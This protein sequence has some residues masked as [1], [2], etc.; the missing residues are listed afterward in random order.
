MPD[1]T[2]VLD[3][4]DMR[5]T[6]VRI[7]HEIVEKNP[8]DHAGQRR[9]GAGPG[10]SGFALVGVHRRGAVLAERLHSLISE[11]GATD[12]RKRRSRSGPSTSAFYRDDLGIR[13]P[14]RARS[15]T[16]RSSTSRSTTARS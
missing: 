10:E 12:R 4:D 14:E 16:P 2:V 7:A 5:R 13:A 6:L 11:L 8:P 3:R 15:C 1:H 9:S